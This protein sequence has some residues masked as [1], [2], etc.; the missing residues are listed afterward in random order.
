MEL[1]KQ[2]RLHDTLAKLAPKGKYGGLGS[3]GMGFARKKRAD[4]LP[5]NPLYSNFVRAGTGHKRS[6]EDA[7]DGKSE[8]KPSKKSK[9]KKSVKGDEPG[10]GGGEGDLAAHKDIVL[11]L[12]GDN[13]NALTMKKLAK[14]M[15]KNTSGLDKKE[16]KQLTS[17]IVSVLAD[18]GRVAVDDD[19][20]KLLPK[21]KPK[22][23][24][25]DKKEEST[26]DGKT[27]M[28]VYMDLVVDTLVEADKAMKS[29]KLVKVCS[30]HFE[31]LE[32]EEKKELIRG[33]VNLLVD[34]GR[35]HVSE[36]EEVELVVVKSNKKEKKEKEKKQRKS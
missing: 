21:P 5:D 27:L 33:T 20:V 34:D 30:Q 2:Q 3:G 10:N 7:E 35:V 25:K 13:D 19:I 18:E 4:S 14:Q 15:S 16:A 9:S 6:F 26:A 1:E 24:K 11:G 8:E 17:G 22:K 23:Q 36:D 31:G 32:K 29:K 28:A 12:L